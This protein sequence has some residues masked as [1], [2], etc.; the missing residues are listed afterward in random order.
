MLNEIHG[1]PAH[2][3]LIHAVVVV[4]PVAALMLVAG[5]LWPAARR[6]FGLLTPAVALVAA[7]LVP[8]TTSAGHWL[9]NRLDPDRKNPLIV[10]HANLATGLLPWTL[11]IVVVAVLVWCLDRRYVLGL[12]APGSDSWNERQARGGI[13]VQQRLGTR[14]V[15]PVW[16]AVLISVLAV[17]AAAGA[18]FELIR[19]GD[20]GAT[21]AW[22]YVRQLP[23]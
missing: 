16:V 13:A 4:V 21:A 11:A 8:L 22:N 15:L 18:L 19:I 17:A 20:S 14:R 3:L 9:Q 2:V 1:L 5:T 12:R 23:G 10:R 7:V 6:R